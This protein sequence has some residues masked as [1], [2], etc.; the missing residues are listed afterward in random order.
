MLNPNEPTGT[1]AQ[2]AVVT[3]YQG[4]TSLRVQAMGFLELAAVAASA[5]LEHRT[6][7]DAIATPILYAVR[8]ATELF[9]KHV[10]TELAEKHRVAIPT[11]KGHGLRLLLKD[12][13]SHIESCLDS[14]AAHDEHCNFERRAWLAEFETIIDQLDK[15]DPDGQSLRYP[16]NQKGAANMDGTMHIDLAQLEQFIQHTAECFREFGERNC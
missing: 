10:V 8:H 2:I 1:S 16:T 15:V 13:R 5:S 9:L 3:T 11:P 6:A 4:A 7:I 12:G 14:E